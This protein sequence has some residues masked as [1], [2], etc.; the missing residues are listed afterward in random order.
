[1]QRP[2]LQ[3]PLPEGDPGFGPPSPQRRA[4]IDGNEQSVVLWESDGDDET[5]RG[6]IIIDVA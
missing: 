5:G 2:W 4:D 3:L 6:V 1:M